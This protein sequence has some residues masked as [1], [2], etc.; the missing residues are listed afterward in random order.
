MPIGPAI[1]R[2][3]HSVPPRTKRTID[4]GLK[5]ATQAGQQE[6]DFE[7]DDFSPRNPFVDPKP[8]NAAPQRKS[9]SWPPPP[10]TAADRAIAK[11]TARAT[12]VLGKF[13]TSRRGKS[14]YERKNSSLSRVRLASDEPGEASSPAK[15]AGGDR[16]EDD[17]SCL[18]PE[19]TPRET[20]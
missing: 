12:R 19:L 5:D 14:L 4:G 11:S 6:N 18:G 9:N 13:K 3:A 10:K 1:D 16:E 15:G 8:E 17:E 7:L 20:V 2:P